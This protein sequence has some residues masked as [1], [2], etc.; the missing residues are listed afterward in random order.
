MNTNHSKLSKR[1]TTRQRGTGGSSTRRL[2]VVEPEALLRWSLS[3]YLG[4]WFRVFAVES[5]A[6]ANKILNRRKVDAAVVSDDLPNH[7]ADVVESRVRAAN[8]QARVIRTASSPI[9]SC[10]PN[11]AAGRIEKPFKLSELA[12]LL[13][14]AAPTEPD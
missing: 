13:S 6:A 8:T 4:R 10:P 2:L 5:G 14:D 9:E 12:R 7:E 11:S 3:T 1:K